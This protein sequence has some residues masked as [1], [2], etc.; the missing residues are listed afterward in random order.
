MWTYELIEEVEY[1]MFDIIAQMFTSL[2]ADIL[3]VYFFPCILW[4]YF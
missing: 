4:R 3:F 2:H 1:V